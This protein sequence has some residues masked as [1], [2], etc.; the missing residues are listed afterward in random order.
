MKELNTWKDIIQ[1]LLDGERV[2]YLESGTNRWIRTHLFPHISTVDLLTT[3]QFTYRIKPRTIKI[4]D[5]EVPEPIKDASD[6]SN[7][8]EYY[9]PLVNC[10]DLCDDYC[11]DGD[12][13]DLRLLKRG[14]IHKTKEAAVIHA[15]ALVKISGGSYE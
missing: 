6:M 3:P 10:E 7:G 13:T 1:A 12:H 11:W 14:L 2:E 15:K 4:G 9:F 8:S 5:M